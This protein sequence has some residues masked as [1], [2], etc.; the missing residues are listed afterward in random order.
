MPLR[1]TIGEYLYKLKPVVDTSAWNKATGDISKIVSKTHI[2]FEDYKDKLNELERT[3]K[4]LAITEAKI[5]EL[6]KLSKSGNKVAADMIW[7]EDNGMMLQK[8]T[9]EGNIEKLETEAS[10]MENLLDANEVTAIKNKE[11][12]G[13]FSGA[14]LGAGGQITAFIGTVKQS[15]EKAQEIL[16][17]ATKYSNS[18][19][20]KGSSVF[21]SSEQRDLMTRYGMSS[22]QA[23]GS[24]AVTEVLGFDLSTYGT[25]TK[26]QKDAYKELMGVYQKG[27]NS[28]DTD[29]LEDY[30]DMMQEYQLSVSKYKIELQTSITK[31]FAESEALKRLMGSVE[32]FMDNTVEFLDTPAV[33]W[34]F[35]TFIDFLA[36]IVDIASGAMDL[37]TWGKGS[38]KTPSKVNNVNSNYYIYGS[39]Y[40]NNETLAKAI[41]L[42]SEQ[43]LEG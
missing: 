32:R 42:K 34:F 10:V 23:A 26:G 19:G 16:D 35:D 36:G 31:L 30:Y 28:I 25:W 43:T 29:K 7:N 33:Q 17:T 3:K 12:M 14:I 39:D 4:D 21:Y 27:I 2:K 9:L 38:S 18:L 15:I 22:S 41:A 40:S 24:S 11:I 37:L 20:I 1:N 5:K 8:T 13:K 6:Q